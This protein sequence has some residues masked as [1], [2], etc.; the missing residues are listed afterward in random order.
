MR[1]RAIAAL[2]D[3]GTG[4]DDA[5]VRA[6]GVQ[7]LAMRGGPKVM[8]HLWRALRDPDAEVQIMAVENAKSKDQGIAL[9]QKA[10]SDVDATIRSVAANRLNQELHRVDTE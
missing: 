2:T 6:Y 1:S 5:S 10:L 9:L 4:D 3:S 7:A 8:R